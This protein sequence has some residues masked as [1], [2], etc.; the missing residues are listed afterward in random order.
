VLAVSTEKAKS[1]SRRR[2]FVIA[3]AAA[4]FAVAFAVRLLAGDDSGDPV[5]L[6]AI[7]PVALL[8]AELGI[9]AGLIGS[10]VTLGMLIAWVEI[11][12]VSLGFFDWAWRIAVFPL[13]AALAAS[14]AGRAR[15]AIA[16]GR[17]S[18]ERLMQVISTAHEGFVSMDADGVI[19]AWNP[20]AEAI[21]GW[22][23]EDA[24]G[25]TVV[26]TIVPPQLREAHVNGL[27][28]FLTTGEGP[29]IDR[30][31]ELEALHRDGHVLPIEITISAIREDGDWTFHAFLHEITDRKRTERELRTHV[32]DLGSVIE[33]TRE[34]ARS[35]DAASA[36]MAICEGA[37]EVSGAE[38]AVLFQ[39]D[40]AGVGLRAA[41]AAG[42]NVEGVLLPFVGEPAGALRAFTSGEPFFLADVVGHPAVA[43]DVVEKMK[44]ISVLWQP[45]LRE[46][47]TIGV[48]TVVW[49]RP[50]EAVSPRLASVMELLAAEA[51]VAIERADL[52]ARLENMARTDDLTGLP[53]RR[54]WDEELPR[55]LARGRRSDRPVCVAMLDLDRFK[56]YNDRLG[57]LAGDRL[58][59]EAAGAWRGA[60]RETDRLARYGGEEFSVVLPDCG[61]ADAWQLV[62]RL[63]SVTP[64][65]ETC[66]A[67]VA[68]WDADETPE[69]LVR[70]ADAALYEAKRTGRNRSVTARPILGT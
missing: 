24:V 64:G 47:N 3:A 23:A 53:N 46:G 19:I 36:R 9:V 32:A 39:P 49:Q 57:H 45:V 56:D 35:T 48:L 43:Q 55:E 2:L 31:T 12:D 25:R 54:A 34:L 60:L 70:R 68:Q 18:R 67:G 29:M 27:R 69:G 37:R 44:A 13:L 66:S 4:L 51:T 10:L 17:Q 6:L 62:E 58:L 7:V 11:E 41:A 5:L 21:F 15:D 14:L 61:L 22:P 50:I 26:D 38:A 63:R 20:E 42:T 59:K 8:A 65:S 52:L 1:L 16:A 40:P 33:A 30:R 28:R